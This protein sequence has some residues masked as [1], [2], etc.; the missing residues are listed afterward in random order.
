MLRTPCALRLLPSRSLHR[1]IIARLATTTT[2]PETSPE[3]P[4][5]V[6]PKGPSVP[7][8]CKEGTVLKGLNILKDG[9]DPVALADDAY[10][11]WLWSLLDPPKKD[12]TPEEQLS[13]KYLRK[14][15]KEKIKANSIAKRAR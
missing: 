12:W 10:P 13:R 1:S 11:D 14:L 2:A 3:P 6:T 4:S 9:K 7:S 8:S 5:T 15:T